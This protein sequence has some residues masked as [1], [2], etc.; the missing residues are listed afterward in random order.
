MQLWPQELHLTDGTRT[1]G[2][3]GWPSPPRGGGAS[4]HTVSHGASGFLLEG[5]M[6]GSL[7]PRSLI[8]SSNTYISRGK[9]IPSKK[10]SSCSLDIFPLELCAL[11]H[12]T[13]S[14]G[15]RFFCAWHAFLCLGNIHPP[16]RLNS[17]AFSFINPFLRPLEYLAVSSS[18]TQEYLD[19]FL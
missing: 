18:N 15:S 19:A 16:S 17:N 7:A 6:V 1:S 3:S 4:A 13:E 2:M 12:Q 5:E 10:M 8:D 14:R 9:N 11:N